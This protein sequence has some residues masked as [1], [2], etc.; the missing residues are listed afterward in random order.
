MPRH[1]LSFLLVFM[2]PPAGVRAQGCGPVPTALVLS[3][4]GV[5]GLAHI[6]V[7]RTLDS[8]GIH[9]DLIVGTSMG[10]M[11]GALY[12]SGYTAHQVEAIARAMPF[13]RAFGRYDPNAPLPF[14][15][16]H[17]L[18]VWEDRGHRYSLQTATIRESEVNAMINRSLLQGNLAAR[19]D[20]DRLPIRFRAVATNLQTRGV[21]VLS[22][23]DLAQAVRASLSVPLMFEPVRRS[24]SLLVD[25]GLSANIPVPQARALG[26]WRLIISDVTGGE[27]DS[28][29]LDSPEG[30]LARL[31]DF[32][33]LQSPPSLDSGDVWIRPE[34]KR[35][36]PL[37]FTPHLVDT[38]MQLG[39]AAAQTA[40][41]DSC[42][43]SPS[44]RPVLP[45]T[46]AQVQWSGGTAGDHRAVGRTLGLAKGAQVDT[47]A[48]S[49]G[50]EE[51]GDRE[52]YRGVWLNPGG[53][54][55]QVAFSPAILPEP[56]RLAAGSVAYSSD[57]GGRVWLGVMDR[58]LLGSSAQGS[59]A[60]LAGQLR[61]DFVLDLR[62]PKRAAERPVP[63]LGL[64]LAHENV[65]YYL[66]DSTLPGPAQFS[67]PVN[68]A[69]LNLGVV[70][71]L[72]RTWAVS[73]SALGSTWAE[74]GS[75]AQL[76]GGVE[77]TMG[78]GA[79]DGEPGLDARFSLTGAY[80]RLAVDGGVAVTVR[81]LRMALTARYG[82]GADLPLQLTFPLGGA[83]A[84]PG[85]HYA[86]ERG[87]REAMAKLAFIHPIVEP[88]SI[89]L[90]AAT[91][92]VANGGPALPGG[93]WWVGGRAGLQAATPLGVVRVDY[94]FTRDDMSLVTVR[95]GR[96]F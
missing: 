51:L 40:L 77:A 92:Q 84:F 16:L 95:L 29:A 34:V 37:E 47:A 22:S 5:K 45:E 15:A 65:R 39:E 50:M 75:A 24:D 58:A 53:S 66:T 10:A 78:D 86:E 35:F 44:A 20:F 19:G 18:V 81:R 76:T 43:T 33:F 88:V 67:Q 32:L 55:T 30:V 52:W 13:G 6:G 59:V 11:V 21:V 3:G 36:K 80:T 7:L 54:G 4:G 72:G 61:Q 41:T 26:R 89:L 2:I 62:L 49:R 1:L 28:T 83:D 90:E 74:R 23:G 87:D 42:A 46:I 71:S 9:P 70:R 38:L 8:L 63:V 85:L 17:P 56:N 69:S 14:R 94:G 60:I 82:W 68:E 73:L 27:G 93:S 57:L 64:D 48:I 96:W 12:A 25:G 31:V 91:G 79:P